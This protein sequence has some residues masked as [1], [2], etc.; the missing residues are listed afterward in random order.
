MTSIPFDTQLVLSGPF[1]TPRQMLEEQEVD[2]HLSIHNDATAQ[3]L[4]FKAGPIEG[5]THFSQ[6]VPLLYKIWGQQWLTTG[7]ISAHYQNMCIEGDEVKAYAELPGQGNSQIRIWAEKKDGTLVLSGTASVGP[8]HP[9]TALERRL[10]SLRPAGKL[11]ILRDVKVG[12]KGSQTEKIKMDFDQRMGAKYPFSLNNKLKVITE[13]SPWYTQQG[14]VDSPW[15]KPIIPL[16]MVSVL[17]Q[18]TSNQANFPVRGPA[19]SLFVDQEIRMIKGPLFVGKEYLLNR[20]IIALS[21]S[22]RTE[23][24]WTKTHVRDP[25]NDEIVAV[26]ILNHAILKESFAGYKNEA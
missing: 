21:E 10:R 17:T 12:D 14:S 4:G 11:V 23:S 9:E 6:F 3:T 8:E 5:P 16:E 25:E 26:T 19:I 18:Y 15:K 13:M 22:H 2:G 24:Y 1:R 20:E 7:C